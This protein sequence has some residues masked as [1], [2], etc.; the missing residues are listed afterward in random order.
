MRSSCDWSSG[1][2][3]EHSI[4]NA[5]A[6][7]IRSA[8]HYVYIENQFFSE[9]EPYLIWRP[10]PDICSHRYWGRAIPRPQYRRQGHCRCLRS[11]GQGRQK[12]PRHRHHPGHSWICRRPQIRRCGWNQ[13]GHGPYRL[14]P[15][16]TLVCRAIMDYQYKSICRGEHSIFGQISAQ[17]VDPK[18]QFQ[19]AISF[20]PRAN[21]TRPSVLLQSSGVRSAQH[22]SCHGQTRGKI[23]RKVPGCPT[24]A[25]SGDYGRRAAHRAREASSSSSSR[26]T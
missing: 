9:D 18:S 19:A 25:R 1:I 22:D 24:R 5:Y 15:W 8:E 10:F 4:Q 16:L 13:V 21:L 6:D 2:L 20:W 7:I 23:R 17:G 12:I 26:S 14:A 3:V 11:C